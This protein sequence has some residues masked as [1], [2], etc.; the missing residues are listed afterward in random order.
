[1]AKQ[2]T[3]IFNRIMM[4]VSS[5]GARLFRNHVG[6][7]K[8]ATGRVHRFGLCKGSSDGI[9]W[10]SVVITPEMA[11][12]R[13]AVF[14][15]IEAKTGRGRPTKEQVNF[16]NQVRDAGGYAGIARNDQDA[17]DIIAGIKKPLK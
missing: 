3:N 11:G 6:V 17:V 10:H 5:E 13:V 16:C 1:M 15:A 12:R 7:V 4:A 8:D 9:G 2:E 14:V